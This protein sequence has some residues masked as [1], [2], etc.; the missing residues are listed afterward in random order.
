MDTLPALRQIVLLARDLPTA[1][2]TTKTFLGLRT[3]IRD[4]HSMAELG[5]EHEVLAIQ[6]TFVEIVAPLSPD[7]SP[8]RLLA[9]RGE[10]GYMVVLQVADLEAV[11]A[12]AAEIGLKP[13]MHE[14]FEGNPMSQWHPRDLGTLAEI[15]EMRVAEWHFC[16]AL[17]DTG[18]TE[19]VA[20]IVAAEIAV[21]DPIEYTRRWATLLGVEL[22]DGQTRIA[23]HG[24]ELRFIADPAGPGLRSVELAASDPVAAGR[25]ATLC[26][27][28]FSIVTGVPVNSDDTP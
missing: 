19:V 24:R 8:G 1:L 20:D 15:D 28:A 17:S 6:D 21:P 2:D 12:R 11:L 9:R 27:V 23:L 5:F 22:P 25:H 10:G 14:E 16:P 4:E 13:I 18:S 7:S 26:G 3:G